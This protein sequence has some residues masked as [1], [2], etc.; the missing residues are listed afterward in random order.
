MK[1]K[2]T[3]HSN[4]YFPQVSL[5]PLFYVVILAPRFWWI[6]HLLA[7]HNSA[8]IT[9]RIYKGLCVNEVSQTVV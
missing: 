4:M 5:F 9:T 2:E 1:F 3:G 6:C 8:L 7:Q